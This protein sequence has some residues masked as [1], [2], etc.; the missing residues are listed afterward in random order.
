MEAMLQ[1]LLLFFT[2]TIPPVLLGYLF[3][4]GITMGREDEWD[5][6]SLKKRGDRKHPYNFHP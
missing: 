3:Y 2:I 6:R 1:E 5:N 4:L